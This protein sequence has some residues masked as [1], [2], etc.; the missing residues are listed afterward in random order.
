MWPTHRV[1]SDYFNVSREI[2]RYRTVPAMLL[3]CENQDGNRQI[4]FNQLCVV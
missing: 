1:P 3:A 4:F 2:L